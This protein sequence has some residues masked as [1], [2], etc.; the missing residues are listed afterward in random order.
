MNK[1]NDDKWTTNACIKRSW[2]RSGPVNFGYIRASN[3]YLWVCPDWG[4][5]SSRYFTVSG[6]KIK[7]WWGGSGMGVLVFG[8]NQQIGA[9]KKHVPLFFSWRLWVWTL[10]G[11]RTSNVPSLVQNVLHFIRAK[12]G[13]F[14]RVVIQTS[15]AVGNHQQSNSA[16]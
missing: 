10:L 15:S 1:R 2:H 5:F 12:M 7:I 11:V 16:V 13:S 4:K 9:L 6:L 3:G 8:F 14:F